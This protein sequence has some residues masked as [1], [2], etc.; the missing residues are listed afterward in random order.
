[1]KRFEIGKIYVPSN[2]VQSLFFTVQ[3]Q[4]DNKKSQCHLRK[5]NFTYFDAT[6]VAVAQ[7]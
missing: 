4:F 3:N 6:I 7:N 5:T 1:M 2:E